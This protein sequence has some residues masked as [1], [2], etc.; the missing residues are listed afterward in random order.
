MFS[1]EQI[2][3]RMMNMNKELKRNIKALRAQAIMT[4]ATVRNLKREVNALKKIN[5]RV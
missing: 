1:P 3:T 2:I 4:N 5:N